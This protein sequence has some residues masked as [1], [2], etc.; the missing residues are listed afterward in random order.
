MDLYNKLKDN[1]QFVLLSIG[2]CSRDTATKQ[3]DLAKKLGYDWPKLFDVHGCLQT[4]YDVTAIP[5]IVLV[6]PDGV[7][8][9]VGGFREMEEAERM[10]DDGLAGE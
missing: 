7:V 1:E 4:M 5:T 8:E 6:N 10:L 2:L 3:R 9:L